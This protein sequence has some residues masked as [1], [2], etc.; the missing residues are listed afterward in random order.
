MRARRAIRAQIDARLSRRRRAEALSPLWITLLV[1]AVYVASFVLFINCPGGLCARPEIGKFFSQYQLCGGA[2]A[3]EFL[4]ERVRLW[5]GRFLWV[6]F[7]ALNNLASAAA[8][9]I[10]LRLIHN[11]IGG[12]TLARGRAGSFLRGSGLKAT[13]AGL[14]LLAL[15]LLLPK[16]QPPDPPRYRAFMPQIYDLLNCA[17]A[18]DL[19]AA[20]PVTFIT[21]IVGLIVVACVVLASCVIIW[22]ASGGRRQRA[23]ELARRMGYLRVLLYAGTATLVT[24]V[25]RISVTFH[26]GLAH[27]PP[28]SGNDETRAAVAK[29]MADFNTSFVSTQAGAYTLLLAAIYIPAALVLD[30]RA[31]ALARRVLP[32]MG[33][34]EREE[35]LRARGLSSSFSEHLPRIVAIL[36]PFLAG[37]LGDLI[38]FLSK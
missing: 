24:T 6:F 8:L 31:A 16:H 34:K 25:L 23:G 3:Q 19:P 4:I 21:L 15:L 12:T 22:P 5:P 11:S 28:V 10:S 33:K 36:G 17:P 37:P 38:G 35:W 18:A 32:Q 2:P 26:W 27:L 29:V 13:L 1:V 30:G 14:L 7:T 9:V 20:N